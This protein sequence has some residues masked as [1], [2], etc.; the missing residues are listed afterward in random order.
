VI[1]AVLLAIAFLAGCGGDDG[2]AEG[3]TTGGPFP[4]TIDHA[5][6][7]TEIPAEPTRVVALGQ[8]DPDTALALGVTPVGA[9]EAFSG[10]LETWITGARRSAPLMNTRPSR[11]LP[12]VIALLVALLGVAGCG[13]DDDGEPS[14]ETTPAAAAFPVTIAQADGAVTLESAPQRVIALDF[15]SADAAL[16]LGVVPVGMAEISYLPEGMH[17]WTADALDGAATEVFTIGDGY[18]LEEIAALDPDV[19]LAV[20]N[21]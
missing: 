14:E 10:G 12:L 21:A 1:A 2:E 9:R 11:V 18:P 6:G 8:T 16:A 20:G 13:S 17:R 19:I 4:V 15:P 3:G 5:L 7:T